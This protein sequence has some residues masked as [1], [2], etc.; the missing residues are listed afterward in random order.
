MT[1]DRAD[2]RG[3][4]TAP[5]DTPHLGAAPPDTAPLDTAPPDTAP[6]DRDGF[7][8]QLNALKAASSYSYQ[9]LARR[10]G[11]P[12][13]TV[14]GWCTGKHLP[15]PRDNDVFEELLTLFGIDDTDGWMS[16]LAELR[17]RAG[18]HAATNPYRG[19]ES[20]TEDDHA[21]YFGRDAL[22]ERVLTLID[23][24]LDGTTTTRHRVVAVVGA[25]GSGKTSLLRAGVG[26]RLRTTDDTEVTYLSPGDDPLQELSDAA[27]RVAA[28]P[29]AVPNGIPNAGAAPPDASRPQRIVVIIDRFEVLL[30]DAHEP[31]LD[32]VIELLDQLCRG[33]HTAVVVGLRADFFHR[34]T[35]VPPLLDGLQHDPVVV[36]PVTFEEATDCIVMPARRAGY[37][38][39]P[40]L[41]VE[42]IA[43]FARHVEARGATEALPLLSHVLYLLA[44][45]ADDRHLSVA[46]YREIG[47]LE[48]ALERSADD[49]FRTLTPTEQAACRALFTQLVE[50]GRNAL[51]TRRT[52]RLDDVIAVEPIESTAQDLRTVVATFADR[53]LLTT[54]VDS[55]TIS[56]E[57]LLTAWPQLGQWIDDERDVLAVVRRVKEAA[58][59]W[60]ESG[61]DEHA[62]I[63]GNLLDTSRALLSSAT[64]AKLDEH[65]RRFVHRSLAAAEQQVRRDAEILSR[66]LAMQ[67]TVLRP[68]DPSLSAQIGLIA[69]DTAPTS[70]SRSVILTATA[71]P[72]GARH[73]G[74]PGP[75]A[76]AVSGDRRR[77]AVTNSVD[78][79]VTL[80]EHNGR[81]RRDRVIAVTDPA[82]DAYAVAL[83][84]DG[85]LLAIAGTDRVATLVDLDAP[86]EA[87]QPTLEHSGHAFGG[88][89]SPAPSTPPAIALQHD[90]HDVAGPL[91][92]LAFDTSGTALHVG[93]AANGAARWQVGPGPT[94]SL[95]DVAERPGTMLSIAI[96]D[97]G[98]TAASFMD[99]AVEL[100]RA[101]G[102]LAWSDPGTSDAPASATA[103]TSDGDLLVVGYRTGDLRAWRIDHTTT[104]IAEPVAELHREFATWI[105]AV[106][107]APSGHC[108]A[109][110]SSDGRVRIWDTTTWQAA[111][112]DLRHPTVVTG[113]CFGSDD[114][115]LTTAE[116]GTLRAWSVPDR[117]GAESTLWAADFDRLGRRL[118]TCS[119]DHALVHDASSLGT[120]ELS[121]R[122]GLPIEHRLL[123][124]GDLALTGAGAITPEGDA[125]A[126][127]TRQGTVLVGSLTDRAIDADADA[128]ATTS[129]ARLDGLGAL[130][131]FVVISD[132]GE[133]IGAVDNG[134]GVCVWR[135]GPHGSFDLEGQA[136]VAP[137]AL[138][139]DVDRSGSILA[140]MSEDGLATLF[141]LPAQGPT[142][143]SPA[144]RDTAAPAETSTPLHT[145]AP[146]EL[147][148]TI[149]TGRSF[150]MSVATHPALPVIAFG[151]ADRTVTIWSIDDPSSPALLH[152][153]TGPA[154]HPFSLAFTF[155]GNRL[156]AGSTDGWAWIWDTSS[157]A[158]TL[159]RATTDGPASLDEAT[160]LP[161]Y[162]RLESRAGGVYAVTTSPD[163]RHLIGGGPGGRFDCWIID[164]DLAI[165]ALERAVGDPVTEAE[166]NHYVPAVPFRPFTPR[167]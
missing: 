27:A 158:A 50:L 135:R 103:M 123:A 80:F 149:A 146:L 156:A 142:E 113:V 119:A 120:T 84:P 64:I 98:W 65:E 161:E 140:V 128:D 59:N 49:A 157:V 93:G 89:A 35:A 21:D 20:F 45:R 15:Y 10:I 9:A 106:A 124:P 114:E 122:R 87:G 36:G 61:E 4:D 153:L 139:V 83:S 32:T 19:L 82:A 5:L 62:L 74:Q 110:A 159:H 129:W 102:T 97:H 6:V 148:A 47:G 132:D 137:P 116:D 86:T 58:A 134:G 133:R 163:G 105:N 92:T 160:P 77:L 44:A 54:D 91:H 81:W 165:A 29:T 63:S 121:A 71:S 138:A 33:P 75:T 69:H 1:T 141:R 76:V 68:A 57:A 41:V 46:A 22:T 115:L 67:A 37:T 38:V 162:A 155:D 108:I 127:G 7:A 130:V 95:H 96:D 42:L 112:D 2:D 28:L 72:P 125:V 30:T 16:T 117:A 73:L 70:V 24:R 94:A 126:L 51:P 147:V 85:R 164:D 154:G 79:T 145:A 104:E 118:L 48:H 40:D 144:D 31:I 78:G 131:E 34:A 11:R 100:R 12:V 107:L 166:W 88:D 136:A 14:H 167:H 111:D 13:S 99:G 143:E 152:R 18:G 17:R 43:E 151:N 39:A 60:L 52:A 66:Q 26:A 3:G 53:R 109:A 25:S 101:D 90:A 55:V 56:H 150:A 23:E 8:E